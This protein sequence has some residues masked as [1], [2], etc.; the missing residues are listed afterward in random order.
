[1]ADEP[2]G[3]RLALESV[4]STLSATAQAAVS[5]YVTAGTGRAIRAHCQSSEL[6]GVPRH[7]SCNDHNAT[8]TD[9]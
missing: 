4:V 9:Q 2:F 7:R 3:L 1:M 5:G 8:S 6:G